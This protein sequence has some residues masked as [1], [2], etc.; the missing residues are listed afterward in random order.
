LDLTQE[1]FLRAYRGIAKLRGDS[2]FGFWLFH[3][4]HNIWR[5]ELRTRSA[6]KRQGFEVPLNNDSPSSP[7]MASSPA[8]PEL[9]PL[10]ELLHGESAERLRKA[11]DTLPPQ[12]RR[13]VLLRVHQDLKY[14]EIA[15]LMGVSIE[16]VKSHLYQARQQ[17]L[18]KM[19]EY[20]NEPET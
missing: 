16:T 9:D 12:M 15:A 13:C 3:I 14:R 2:D 5:N 18:Q 11:L 6:D 1:T 17:L 8:S 20:F 7:D 19:S 4:A 10:S